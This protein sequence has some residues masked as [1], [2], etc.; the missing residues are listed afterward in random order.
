MFFLKIRKLFFAVDGRNLI[1]KLAAVALVNIIKCRK[2]FYQFSF[3]SNL[4][5]TE[6]TFQT[7]ICS[8]RL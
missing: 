3:Q 4:K 7:I 1:Q 5:L 6:K 2:Q 8:S